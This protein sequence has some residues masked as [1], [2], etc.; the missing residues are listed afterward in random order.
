[1]GKKVILLN[2]PSSS[3]KSSLASILQKLIQ[4]K[5]REEYGVVSIDDFLTMMPDKAIYEDDVFAVSP[6][7]CKNRSKCF[8]QNKELSLS[9]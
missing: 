5:K 9:M 2:G 1:M 8:I 6:E 3:G 7:L 4:D